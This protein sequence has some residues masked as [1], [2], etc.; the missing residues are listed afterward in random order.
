MAQRKVCHAD[1]LLL[2]RVLLN[3]PCPK[4]IY[5]SAAGL[6]G[7][8]VAGTAADFGPPALSFFSVVLGS[9]LLSV[10]GSSFFSTSKSFRSLKRGSI[11][12]LET[13]YVHFSKAFSAFSLSWSF[14]IRSWNSLSSLVLSSGFSS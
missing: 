9:S 4:S 10:L 6:S 12:H 7:M 1:R 2:F 13:T 5:F 3:Q 8:G 11:V 14:L